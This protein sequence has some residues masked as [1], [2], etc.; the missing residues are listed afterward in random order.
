MTLVCKICAKA[1]VEQ[2]PYDF[3]AEENMLFCKLYLHSVDIFSVDTIKDHI[4]S[5]NPVG[6]KSSTKSSQLKQKTI[7]TLLKSKEVREDF[8]LDF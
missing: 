7:T 5:K 6:K 4:K 3:Y 2:F 8:V 1:K